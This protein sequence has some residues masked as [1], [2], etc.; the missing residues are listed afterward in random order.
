M[1]Q[2]TNSSRA[3]SLAASDITLARSELSFISS[4][5]H[6]DTGSIFRGPRASNTQMDT[7]QVSSNC[8]KRTQYQAQ[9]LFNKVSLYLLSKSRLIN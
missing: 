7:Q 8:P 5:D 4:T 1:S 2:I 9:I 3:T 6:G